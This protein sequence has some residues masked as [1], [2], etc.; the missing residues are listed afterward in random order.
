MKSFILYNRGEKRQVLP[1]AKK[2]KKYERI[3]RK[4]AKKTA[5]N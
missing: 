1:N 5:K 2:V 4:D 3:Q